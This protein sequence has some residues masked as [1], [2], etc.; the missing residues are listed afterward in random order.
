[1][2]ATK[3]TRRNSRVRKNKAF[4][5]NMR[6][7]IKFNL[8]KAVTLN[9]TTLMLDEIARVWWTGAGLLPGLNSRKRSPSSSTILEW[10]GQPA[11]VAFLAIIQWYLNC[12]FCGFRLTRNTSAYDNLMHLF[13]EGGC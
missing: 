4:M 2:A 9:H 6:L 1:M 5:M 12:F 10:I 13:E 11:G 8:P 7:E 3:L